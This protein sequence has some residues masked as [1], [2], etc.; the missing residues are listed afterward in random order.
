MQPELPAP[1][2]EMS[3]G[4]PSRATHGLPF[5]A[6]PAAQGL[7]DPR[8]EHDACGVN[9][10]VDLQ[11][12]TS[13]QIVQHGVGALCNLDHRGAAGADEGTGDGAGILIQVP[14]RFFREVVSFELPPAGSYATGIAF[15]PQSPE[16]ARLAVQAVEKLVA[17]EGLEVL[18]WRAVPTDPSIL[19]E[20][21]LRTMP[22]FAQLFVAGKGLTGIALDRACYV[23][24]KR[25]EHEIHLPAGADE[26]NEAMGG[27][28][29]AHDGVYF[30]SLSCRTFVWKGM[31]T[32][33]Q[34]APF[35]PDLADERV[36]SALALVHSRFSTNTFP[37]VAAQRTRTAT[38]PTTAKSTRSRATA[39][40][41]A[42]RE[43][44]LEERPHP[45]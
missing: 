4:T 41:C 19:G 40:G 26:V 31:L 29:Q 8:F 34:L 21:S 9:F 25:C 35:F 3:P 10:V 33:M 2:P 24:R 20:G 14:D 22:N 30:P 5:V 11:G 44:M 32:T 43:T 1:A 15:L 16:A 23:L 13:H 38:S 7:Y 18:G 6:T 36:E 42:A 27:M 12:R 28:S 17:D 39:T 45:R 37:S